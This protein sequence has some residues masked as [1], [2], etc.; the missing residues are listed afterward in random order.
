MFSAYRGYLFIDYQLTNIASIGTGIVRLVEMRVTSHRRTSKHTHT[1]YIYIYI[2]IYNLFML[3]YKYN[4]K[5]YLHLY[6][7]YIYIY[8][9]KRK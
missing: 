8:I 7:I 3:I 4:I 6:F 5:I 1:L 9:I 2:Y